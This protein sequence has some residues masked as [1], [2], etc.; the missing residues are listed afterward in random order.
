MLC[1]VLLL[2]LGL[3]ENWVGADVGSGTGSHAG[4]GTRAEN[5]GPEKKRNRVPRTG[6]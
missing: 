6:N 3:G 4:V 1:P 5:W 2:V